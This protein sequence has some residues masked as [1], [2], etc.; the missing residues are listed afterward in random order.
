M[1]VL[2]TRPGFRYATTKPSAK[3]TS[4][5]ASHGGGRARIPGAAERSG[6]RIDHYAVVARASQAARR[7]SV[8]RR[9]SIAE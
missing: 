7:M 2:A 1:A 9:T 3:K 8:Q 5:L 6:R 4:S